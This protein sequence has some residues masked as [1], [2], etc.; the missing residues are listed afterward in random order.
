M[1]ACYC[2]T[3]DALD[4]FEAER[5]IARRE[6]RCTECFCT[7]NP[8]ERY[9][10]A[11]GLAEGTW[12]RYKTCH[13]CL[14]QLI[15]QYLSVS[16]CLIVALPSKSINGCQIVKALRDWLEAVSCC[17]CWSYE[18]LMEEAPYEITENNWKPGYKFAALR[19]LA[20]IKREQRS[21]RAA[22]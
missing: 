10:R 14:Y 11:S 13:R 15:Y 8:G 7:I 1:G 18:G 2:D 19:L 3:G 21:R 20:A 9:E 17:F 6:H 4:C 5:P 16:L 12:F 22:R